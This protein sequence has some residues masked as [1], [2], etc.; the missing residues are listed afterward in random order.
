MAYE[1][2]RRNSKSICFFRG[3]ARPA[4]G[5]ANSKGGASPRAKRGCHKGARP[6]ED[7]ADDHATVSTW[8]LP[9]EGSK[10]E[11]THLIGQGV[12]ERDEIAAVAPRAPELPRD[13][14]VILEGERGGL[15]PTV[16]MGRP[17]E[18]QRRGHPH[19]PVVPLLSEVLSCPFPEGDGEGTPVGGGRP[20]RLPSP[21][22]AT[23]GWLASGIGACP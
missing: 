16:L 4:R 8:V 20:R 23:A 2:Q 18:G 6:P 5:G 7:R 17:P 13:V 15:L 10:G 1:V 14:K 21:P 3:G 19:A 12:T 9:P 22:S 11:D